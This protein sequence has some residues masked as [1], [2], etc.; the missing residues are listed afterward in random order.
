MTDCC[1]TRDI[2][3][4]LKK[5]ICRHIGGWYGVLRNLLG[6]P[7]KLFVVMKDNRHL[8]LEALWSISF[9]ALSKTLRSVKFIILIFR[10]A[11][12]VRNRR[13]RVLCASFYIRSVFQ[14][15]LFCYNF[16]FRFLLSREIFS[17]NTYNYS[18]CS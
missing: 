14:I 18:K 16:H 11:L 9:W 8:F 4:I 2:I 15:Y 10:G 5:N 17:H 7:L 1:Y 6:S 3:N 12:S 13:H